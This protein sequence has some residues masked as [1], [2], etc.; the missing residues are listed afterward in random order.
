MSEKQAPRLALAAKLF[1]GVPSLLSQL[2]QLTVHFE[3]FFLTLFLPTYL[4]RPVSQTLSI[5]IIIF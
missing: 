3:R 5:S 4:L 1:L 2:V